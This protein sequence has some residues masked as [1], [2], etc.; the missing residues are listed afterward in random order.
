MSDDLS[1][2]DLDLL[3]QLNESY[4]FMVFDDFIGRCSCKCLNANV[5][6][7]KHC[8]LQFI[9]AFQLNNFQAQPLG[10]IQGNVSS[11]RFG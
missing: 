10:V 9:V 6:N 11:M 5:M 7:T 4:T 1:F 2:N 8:I 3:Q